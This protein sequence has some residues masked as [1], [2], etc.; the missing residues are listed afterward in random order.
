M[1]AP[2]LFP[3]PSGQPLSRSSEAL[4]AHLVLDAERLKCHGWVKRDIHDQVMVL[5]GGK[6]SLCVYFIMYKQEAGMLLK[7]RLIDALKKE[8]DCRC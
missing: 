4:P 2:P 5:V 8:L 6:G 7:I 1:S 3:G